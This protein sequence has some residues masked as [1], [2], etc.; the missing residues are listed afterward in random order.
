M[1]EESGPHGPARPLDDFLDQGE[2][3][4]TLK[5]SR[6]TVTGWREKGLPAYRLGTRFWFDE[7]EVAAFLRA[8]LRRDEKPKRGTPASMDEGVSSESR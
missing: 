7:A 2:L 3:C 4:A 6:S 8:T 5:V 1:A